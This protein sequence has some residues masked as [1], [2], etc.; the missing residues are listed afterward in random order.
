MR[1]K[2]QVSSL[3]KNVLFM[4]CDRVDDTSTLYDRVISYHCTKI[5]KIIN[6]QWNWYKI[7]VYT[8]VY[9][10]D[11]QCQRFLERNWY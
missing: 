8:P 6:V 7:S 1:K 5:I 2:P 10:R 9:Y 4:W 11:I 3:D